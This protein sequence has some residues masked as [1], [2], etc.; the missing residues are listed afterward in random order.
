MTL[1]ADILFANIVKAAGVIEP[2]QAELNAAY[3]RMS[4]NN[5]PGK[6]GSLGDRL[7]WE[8]L[9]SRMPNQADLHIVSKDGDFASPDLIY[10]KD[11]CSPISGPMTPLTPLMPKRHCN[12]D[13]ERRTYSGL[14]H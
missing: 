9:L 13:M 6:K 12:M 4:L 1:A 7:N 11:S 14:A 10:D 8:Q 2:K 5:P 3:H